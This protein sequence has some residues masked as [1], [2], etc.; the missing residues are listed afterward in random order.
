MHAF[1]LNYIK[2]IRIAF[3]NKR[4]SIVINI[5]EYQQN[6][7]KHFYLGIKEMTAIVLKK[8]VMFNVKLYKEKK[9]IKPANLSSCKG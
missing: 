3:E 4:V 6:S 5:V 2:V 7:E 8:K 1:S 9:V